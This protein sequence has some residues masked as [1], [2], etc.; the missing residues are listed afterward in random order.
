MGRFIAVVIVLVAIALLI[1]HYKPKQAA[2]QPAAPE[3][4]QAAEGPSA[5]APSAEADS[6]AEAPA[7]EADSPSPADL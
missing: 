1:N 4:P 6:P 2:D 3:Q 5:E 7:A